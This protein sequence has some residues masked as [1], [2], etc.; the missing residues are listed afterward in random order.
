MSNSEQ[1]F[2]RPSFPKSKH[3]KL[4]IL[5]Q[6]SFS[7]FSFSFVTKTSHFACVFYSYI[8]DY[9]IYICIKHTFIIQIL[10]H[11]HTHTHFVAATIVFLAKPHI[12]ILQH[13]PTHRAV[14]ERSIKT[15]YFITLA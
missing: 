4:I 3:T 13:L 8:L 2:A 6:F 12:Y 7:E 11:H 5:H 1:L 10:Y 14:R 15:F 9:I